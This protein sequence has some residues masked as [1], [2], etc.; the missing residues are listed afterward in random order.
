MKGDVG[1][2]G[3]HPFSYKEPPVKNNTV[4]QRY[5]RD[6][7]DRPD[8]ANYNF[9]RGPQRRSGGGC[10]APYSGTY[11]TVNEVGPGTPCIQLLAALGCR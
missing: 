1:R 4:F 2:P 7:A 11:L 8:S 9:L 10:E 3:A 6:R 5:I